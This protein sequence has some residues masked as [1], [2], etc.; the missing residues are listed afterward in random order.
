MYSKCHCYYHRH[1]RSYILAVRFNFLLTHYHPFVSLSLLLTKISQ[2]RHKQPTVYK[3][4]S[5]FSEELRG[6]QN[7]IFQILGKHNTINHK[8]EVQFKVLSK[9]QKVHNSTYPEVLHNHP[10]HMTVTSVLCNTRA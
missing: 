7:F 10:L 8:T 1:S 3:N 2:E 6:S 5:Y 4:K 9:Y